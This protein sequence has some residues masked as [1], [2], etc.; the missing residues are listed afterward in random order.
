MLKWLQE[1][2]STPRQDRENPYRPNHEHGS[3]SLPAETS[4][5]SKL[6]WPRELFLSGEGACPPEIDVT[7]P[8]RYV[9]FGPFITLEAGLWRAVCDLEFCPDAA[10][11][12]F[13]LQFGAEPDYTTVELPRGQAGPRRIVIEH[14]LPSSGVVQVRLWLKKA[15][16][17][18]H[19][20]FGGATVEKIADAEPA[21]H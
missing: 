6:R 7:G 20:R 4:G 2:I 16:F 3:A 1:A 14:M 17:H 18:G 19:V 11:R 21:T 9:I 10:L 5:D 8:P 12:V 13:A 15:A